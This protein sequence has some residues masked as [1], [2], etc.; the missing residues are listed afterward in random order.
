MLFAVLP[1]QQIY[2]DLMNQKK[3]FSASL[4]SWL[5]TQRDKQISDRANWQNIIKIIIIKKTA[6]E[7]L[8]F[9]HF[10]SP[11]LQKYAELSD[12]WDY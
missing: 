2:P 3:F 6:L 7:A 12:F 8:A 11:I 1:H 4:S 5:I 9:K 10:S